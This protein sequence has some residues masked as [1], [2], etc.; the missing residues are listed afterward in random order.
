LNQDHELDIRPLSDRCFSPAH[1]GFGG[2]E[3]I[4]IEGKIRVARSTTEL[5]QVAS[6]GHN[7]SSSATGQRRWQDPVANGA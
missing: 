2:E 1:C 5:A 4:E 7:I 3:T 6:R